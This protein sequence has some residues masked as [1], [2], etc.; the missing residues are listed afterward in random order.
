MSAL[1]LPRRYAPNAP[2]I[3]RSARRELIR[4]S[5]RRI[6]RPAYNR[7][8]L[9]GTGV[10]LGGGGG[11]GSLTFTKSISPA[12]WID[13]PNGDNSTDTTFN[14]VPIGTAAADRYVHLNVHFDIVGGTPTGVT[15]NGNS[16]T[17]HV[18]T[19]STTGVAAYGLLVTTGTTANF[20]ISYSAFSAYYVSISGG[21]ITGSAAIS[22][23]S[24][25]GAPVSQDRAYMDL[26]LPSITPVSNGAMVVGVTT[27]ANDISSP[28][29]SSGLASPATGY[30]HYEAAHTRNYFLTWATSLGSAIVA[31][32]SGPG[33]DNMCGVAV[34]YQP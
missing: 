22:V 34:A 17:K 21:Y 20:V 1:I 6:M 16:M 30:D 5:A 19:T 10:P 28:S 25:S 8:G 3:L 13:T 29:W 15:C 32:L 14:S 12:S 31:T 4:P 33:D 23:S 11:G 24:G 26:A 2:A 18:G 7:M 9:L 27:D